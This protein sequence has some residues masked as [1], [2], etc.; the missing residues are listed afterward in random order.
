MIRNL[1]D[2]M[3]TLG[4]LRFIRNLGVVVHEKRNE[5]NV[6]TIK[7]YTNINNEKKSEAVIA[8]TEEMGQRLIAL[9][10]AEVGN[11]KVEITRTKECRFG[12]KCPKINRNCSFYHKKS[13]VTSR[14]SN[15]S[16]NQQG[17]EM[18]LCW[19]QNSCPFGDL[20]KFAHP[21]KDSE[22][23]ADE[24]ISNEAIVKNC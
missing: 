14:S 9:N 2:Q 15:S 3:N 16:K 1:P 23:T 22:S 21:V 17:K 8:M 19:Y 20:C 13:A 5:Y 4:V 10:G 12:E 7:S 18:P 24:K 11:D 6:L